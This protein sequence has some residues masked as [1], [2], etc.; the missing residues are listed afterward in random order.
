MLPS[1]LVV[2]LLSRKF[3]SH[4]VFKV[5]LNNGT[6]LERLITHSSDMYLGVSVGRVCNRIAKGQF[7]IDGKVQPPPHAR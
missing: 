4:S 5:T 1:C 2:T 6:N 3:L 7:S